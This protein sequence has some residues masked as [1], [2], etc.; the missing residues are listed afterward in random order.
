MLLKKVSGFRKRCKINVW[1]QGDH[2][3][4]HERKVR[5][6]HKRIVQVYNPIKEYV[7]LRKTNKNLI[8]RSEKGLLL[9]ATYR[10]QT[11]KKK[12]GQ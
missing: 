3:P 10:L 7:R 5:S 11:A 1:P 12:L 9:C 2:L 6:L 8:A 4:R